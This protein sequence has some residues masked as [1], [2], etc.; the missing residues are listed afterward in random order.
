VNVVS[1]PPASAR[2][3]WPA[4]MSHASIA[5]SQYASSRPHAIAHSVSAGDPNAR[6]PP[7]ASMSA[8]TSPAY[9]RISDRT[10]DCACATTSAR[11]SRETA[12]TRSG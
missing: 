10:D 4:R 12:E 6:T 7:H 3:S 1:V 8:S 2:I 9:A 11:S 5:C